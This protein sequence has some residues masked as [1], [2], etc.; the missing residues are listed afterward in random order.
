MTTTPSPPPVTG[1]LRLPNIELIRVI[2]ATGLC[3]GA[4]S[5][6]LLAAW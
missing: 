1:S 3:T 5:A 4:R 2:Q 6:A